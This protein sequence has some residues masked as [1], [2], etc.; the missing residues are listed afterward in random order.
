[1]ALALL[2]GA[3]SIIGGKDEITLGDDVQE[4]SRADHQT[5]RDSLQA[6]RRAHLLA[7]LSESASRST[8]PKESLRALLH[9]DASCLDDKER[10]SMEAVKIIVPAAERK[11]CVCGATVCVAPSA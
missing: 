7:E 1:M 9:H 5:A 4:S 3:A 8:R 11:P 10:Q 6:L 2:Y